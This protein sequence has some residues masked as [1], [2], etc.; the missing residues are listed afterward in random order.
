MKTRDP[1]NKS[2]TLTIILSQLKFRRFM[3]P[4]ITQSHKPFDRDGAT[5]H[6]RLVFR[7]HAIAHYQ[8]HQVY[9]LIGGHGTFDRGERR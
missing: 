6:M 4:R 3:L 2:Q 9:I 5:G 7:A 8:C 1:L